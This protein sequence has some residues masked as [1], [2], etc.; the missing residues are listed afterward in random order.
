MDR[1]GARIEPIAAHRPARGFTL[2]ELI[3]VIIILGVLAAFAL[4]R[5]SNIEAQA[6]AS[7]VEAMLGATRSAATLA[8]SVSLTSQIPSNAPVTIEGQ[9]V[10]MVNRYPDAPGMANVAN[11]DLTPEAVD[12]QFFGDIA[13]TLAPQGVSSW[14]TCGFAYVRPIPPVIEA[15]LF[16]GPNTSGCD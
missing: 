12:L 7:V 14:A 9:L 6:R 15:P 8:H 10:N 11:I 16:L 3:T 5:F 2:I 13:F 4:P 1:S